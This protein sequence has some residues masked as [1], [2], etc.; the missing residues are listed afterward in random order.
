MRRGKYFWLELGFLIPKRRTLLSDEI[1]K[2]L[3]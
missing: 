2:A 1:E 3:K